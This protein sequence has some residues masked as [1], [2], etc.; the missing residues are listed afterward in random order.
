[1]SKV[2]SPL[3]RFHAQLSQAA[4]V[5]WLGHLTALL[6]MSQC[7]SAEGESIIVQLCYG[8]Q[9]Y[10]PCSAGC[11]GAFFQLAKQAT[12]KLAAS[13]FFIEQ[14]KHGQLYSAVHFIFLLYF[15][16]KFNSRFLPPC[17][18]D[19]CFCTFFYKF[20][21]F[22]FGVKDRHGRSSA[23]CLGQCIHAGVFQL[24]IALSVCC[25][26]LRNSI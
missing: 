21:L 11:Y 26:T 10:R 19:F 5:A 14:W 13:R 23:G 25:S 6:S 8:R 4:V 7:T 9:Q 20:M 24:L 12:N 15:W 3:V 2:P 16:Y 17:L 22:E 18:Q 1:M